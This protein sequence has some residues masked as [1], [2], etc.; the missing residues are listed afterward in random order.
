MHEGF[1][2]FHERAR[3][4]AFLEATGPIGFAGKWPALGLGEADDLDDK[5]VAHDTRVL[6][7]FM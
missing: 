2:G 1:H 7:V 4:E 6:G 3:G 5:G